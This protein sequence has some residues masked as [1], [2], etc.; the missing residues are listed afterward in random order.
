MFAGSFAPVGWLMCD[1]S[2]LPISENEILFQL[3]GTTYGGDGEETF[4]LPN[5]CSRLPINHGTGS[6]GTTY[7]IGEMAGVEQVT[8]TVQQIPAHTHPML[9][10]ANSATGPAPQGQVYAAADIYSASG[11]PP[12][13]MNPAAITPTGGS[14][15]HDNMQ[16]YLVVNYIISLFGLFPS[17]T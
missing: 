14:Q 17:Q 2:T 4:N 16:P 15:P 6:F 11:S 3:I 8:L 7:Q 9:G 1:G 12:V 10:S 13:N 5:L